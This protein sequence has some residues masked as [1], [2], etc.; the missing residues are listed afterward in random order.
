MAIAIITLMGSCKKDFLTP[1][2]LSFYTPEN[3]FNTPEGLKS[4]LVACERNMRYEFFGDGA[5]IIT[6]L[7]FS[8]MAIEGTTDKSGPA[9]D[10]NLQITPTAQLNHTDFNRIGWYWYE[11]YKGI[12]YANTAISYFDQPQWKS[13]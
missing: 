7:I 4:V 12:K 13:E 5:P 2:P 3:T 9:Q 11:G 8:E 10:L 1:Q 6:Q